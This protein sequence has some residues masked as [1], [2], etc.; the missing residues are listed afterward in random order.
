MGI[1]GVTV[2]DL[3]LP[4]TFF[5]SSSSFSSSCPVG[6]E[7]NTAPVPLSVPAAGRHFPNAAEP[8]RLLFQKQV[9][10]SEADVCLWGRASPTS[11]NQC[12]YWMGSHSKVTRDRSATETRRTATVVIFRAQ[13]YGLVQLSRRRW[14]K[15]GKVPR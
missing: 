2:T 7:A 5:P 3:C 4:W 9:L 10:Q 13:T 11:T 1:W 15:I 6:Y 8:V 14:K 12:P